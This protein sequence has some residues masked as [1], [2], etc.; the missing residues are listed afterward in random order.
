M[1]SKVQGKTLGNEAVIAL[2]PKLTPMERGMLAWVVLDP[3]D[4]VLDVGAGDGLVLE[5]LHR[6]M[7]CEICGMSA[8]MEHVKRSRTRLQNADIV[9]AQPQDI[10]WRENAFDA[11]M[12]RRDGQAEENWPEIMAEMLRV[13]RPGGQLVLGVNCYPTPLRQLANLLLREPEEET[14]QLYESKASVMASVEG[15]GFEQVT[16]QQVDLITGVVI[17]WKPA[18]TAE[19]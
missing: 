13:L 3:G 5:Y 6:N 7:E 14:R 15:A 16:W 1:I 10:P 18:V 11:V 4:R 19:T 2:H 8:S 12:I 17:G 9:Y